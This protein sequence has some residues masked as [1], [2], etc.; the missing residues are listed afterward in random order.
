MSWNVV[1][2]Y[3]LHSVHLLSAIEKW[4]NAIKV[5]LML[6]QCE[7]MLVKFELMLV[8]CQINTK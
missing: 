2:G 5:E 3:I 7:L 1:G 8:K 4:A 6:I